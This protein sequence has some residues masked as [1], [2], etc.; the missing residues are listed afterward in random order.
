[1]SFSFQLQKVN[2]SFET[3][4]S[5]YHEFMNR[6]ETCFRAMNQRIVNLEERQGPT[7]EQVERVLRK[8]L[9]E[10]FSD[11]SVQQVSTP[12][13]IKEEECFVKDPRRHTVVRPVQF[14]P[15]SLLVHPEAVP[16]KAYSDT[17]RMLQGNLV[18]FPNLEAKGNQQQ[19]G[20]DDRMDQD[21]KQP[22]GPNGA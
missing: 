16:S 9:A 11:D 17:L 3:I 2:Q 13:V 7:D 10:K 1:M 6:T 8:I 21:I 19:E 12:V 5:W 14:D 22:Q 15:A 18:H 20:G 4:A